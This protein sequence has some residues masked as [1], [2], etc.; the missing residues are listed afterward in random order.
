MTFPNNSI[1]NWTRFMIQKRKFDKKD[2]CEK[3]NQK[4]KRLKSILNQI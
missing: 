3:I 2:D 4:Q 1:K